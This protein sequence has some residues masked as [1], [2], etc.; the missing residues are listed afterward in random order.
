MLTSIVYVGD[1][2]TLAYLQIVR[3]LFEPFLGGGSDFTNDGLR[4]TILE[5]KMIPLPV[6][7]R[8]STVLPDRPTTEALVESFFVNV[9]PTNPV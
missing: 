8:H 2:A 5:K 3:M 6:N 7:M 9:S 1:T 4:H